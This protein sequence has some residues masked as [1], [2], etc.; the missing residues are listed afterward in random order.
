[1]I[2]IG[3]LLKSKHIKTCGNK[4]F[5]WSCVVENGMSELYSIKICGNIFYIP[6]KLRKY[7]RH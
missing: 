4:Y 1:M 5:G 2:D 3:K 7:T 6:H